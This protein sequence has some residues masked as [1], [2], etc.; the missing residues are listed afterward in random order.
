[1][2]NNPQ[3]VIS[4]SEGLF[5][6]PLLIAVGAILIIGGSG[7]V[8]TSYLARDRAEKAE[9]L[10]E[11]ETLQSVPEEDIDIEPS[12][13][14][15][16]KAIIAPAP[17]AAVVAVKPE[18][19]E[20]E[21]P[22][23]QIVVE[24][25]TKA[26][27]KSPGL[28]DIDYWKAEYRANGWSRDELSANILTSHEN[29][30]E[31]AKKI[32]PVTIPSPSSAPVKSSSPVNDLVA[33]AKSSQEAGGSGQECFAA[34]AALGN[35]SSGLKK[36]IVEDEI[37]YDEFIIREY[38]YG[39][40]YYIEKGIGCLSLSFQTIR[41]FYIDQTGFLNGIGDKIIIPDR[42]QTCRVWDAKAL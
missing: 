17:N 42:G 28:S 25:Y 29:G 3:R 4:G 10:L 18:P 23:P 36:Y 19:V 31:R 2:L 12:P 11:N 21:V 13:S 20:V 26:L 35:Y 34:S 39:Q 1:M 15:S 5:V 14:E 22:V 27:G 7:I 24:E 16:P 30:I 6:L 38:P 40:R 32:E 9:P 37:D 33:C 41:P 8:G